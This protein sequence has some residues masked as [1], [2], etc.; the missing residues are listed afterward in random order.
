[1]SVLAEVPTVP[2]KITPPTMGA[3]VAAHSAVHT[4][5]SNLRD[6]ALER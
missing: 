5:L 2:L 3:A 6:E 4:V 1:M